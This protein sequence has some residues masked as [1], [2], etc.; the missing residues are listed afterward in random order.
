MGNKGAEDLDT[1]DFKVESALEMYQI[2][3]PKY[4]KKSN[5][6]N[7]D[8]SLQFQN[9]FKETYIAIID[10]PKNDFV[11]AFRDIEEYNEEQSVSGNYRSAQMDY[12]TE[13]MT[14]VERGTPKKVSI[15]GMDAE[16]VE[17]TASVPEVDYDIYY[18]LTFVEGRE[19]IYMVMQW[20][21][22]E[23]KETYKGTFYQMIDTFKEI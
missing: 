15:N 6:L 3:I 12:F 5:D 4:M 7:Y 1:S 21:L 14:M 18:L 10:E 11:E 9:I 22:A 23:Y 17:F 19:N 2:S 16:Q 13:G 20:T 8:A